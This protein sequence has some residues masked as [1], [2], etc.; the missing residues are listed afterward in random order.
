MKHAYN[1]DKPRSITL[2]GLPKD[3]ALFPQEKQ[4]CA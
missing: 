4:K 2:K 1:K 3:D